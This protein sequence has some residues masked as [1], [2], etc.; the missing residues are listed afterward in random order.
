MADH[1]QNPE[2]RRFLTQSGGMLGGFLA[3][4]GAALLSL[5]AGSLVSK[6]GRS[7]A[8]AADV[9][10]F[11]TETAVAK[12]VLHANEAVNLQGD[13][14]G[15]DLSSMVLVSQPEAWSAQK[16]CN[17]V[18]LVLAHGC[19]AGQIDPK[20][21]R[22]HVGLSMIELELSENGWSHR[23]SGMMNRRWHA[24]SP[25]AI[26]GMRFQENAP[27][28]RVQRL[29]QGMAGIASMALSGWQTVLAC[30][31][32]PGDSYPRFEF[33]EEREKQHFHRD[34]G[35]VVEV[36]PFTGTAIKRFSLGRVFPV[37]AS[38]AAS[39][40]KPVSIYLLGQRE[41]GLGFLFKF[42]SHQRFD[43]RMLTANASILSMGELWVADI[44]KRRWG[45]V[46]EGSGG[47]S[48]EEAMVSPY[49]ATAQFHGLPEP[50]KLACDEVEKHLYV[51]S[52][53][54]IFVLSERLEPFDSQEFEW[55]ETK[56]SFDDSPFE[57]ADQAFAP[58]G[59]GMFF[60]EK[61]ETGP[62]I[63]A[64]TS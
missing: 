1:D 53:N 33:S 17:R 54:K 39:A 41:D 61:T 22:R 19:A 56:M 43:S 11:E 15:L 28:L 36:N 9:A 23:I 47:R 29:S 55:N 31:A 25:V 5:V 20:L 37:S 34:W 24:E 51:H 50:R 8:N 63:F 21:S 38:L 13:P 16:Q 14:L 45:R 26:E 62:A 40:G 30:E 10:S 6:T 3:N 46:F 57:P 32:R 49:Q 58:F 48:W 64:R 60:I 44:E 18:L 7:A 35:W 12:K 27:A 59:A 4:P 42:I 2:R 52:E